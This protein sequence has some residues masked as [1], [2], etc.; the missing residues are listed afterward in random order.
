[1][2]AALNLIIARDR[3]KERVEGFVEWPSVWTAEKSMAHMNLVKEILRCVSITI[4]IPNQFL[5]KQKKRMKV[6]CFDLNT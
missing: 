5:R 3:L 2:H 1:M 4:L 6:S